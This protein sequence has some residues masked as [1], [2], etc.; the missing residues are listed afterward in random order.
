MFSDSFF[1][2]IEDF[3]KQKMDSLGLGYHNWAHVQ[4][5]AQA[6]DVLTKG[7]NLPEEQRLTIRVAVLFHDTGLSETRQGHEDASARSARKFLTGKISENKIV[8]IENLIMATKLSR[9]PKTVG[10]RIM[11]D[12]DLINLGKDFS[13]F[14]KNMEAVLEEERNAGF[15]GTELEWLQIVENLLKKGFFTDTAKRLWG[16]NREKNLA[17]IRQRIRTKSETKSKRLKRK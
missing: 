8:E 15:E 17:R 9:E 14:S 13:H 16:E 11:R 6:A 3:C 2:E 1:S 4:D 12:A 5:F 10:E 7:E